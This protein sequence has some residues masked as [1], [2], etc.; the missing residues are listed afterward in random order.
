M[1]S[2]AIDQG[3]QSLSSGVPP[4]PSGMVFSIM[5]KRSGLTPT[6]ISR[7]SFNIGAGL[8]RDAAGQPRLDEA[9][10]H[11]VNRDVHATQFLGQCLRHTDDTGFCGGIVCLPGV[12]EKTG[13]GSTENRPRLALTT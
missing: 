3:Y 13:H 4:R 12:S 7:P 1:N 2:S 10:G 11:A 8:A 6:L 5:A 9:I